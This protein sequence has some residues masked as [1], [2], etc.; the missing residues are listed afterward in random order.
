[1]KTLPEE[2]ISVGKGQNY[3]L[4]GDNAIWLKKIPDN[5]IDSIVTDPP[6]GISFMARGWDSDKGGRDHWIKWMQ[7][8]ATECKRVLKPGGHAFVWA[9]PR[10][11]HW[12]ATAWENAGFE[13]RDVV[14][15]IFGSGFPKSHNVEKAVQKIQPERSDEFKGIGT[16]LKPA[17]E[18]WILMRKP[19]AEKNVALNVL[20]YGTG[21]INIDESRV[22]AN[23]KEE[24]PESWFNSGKSKSG[25]PTYD[26]NLK[27][28]TESTV[29]ERL[30]DAGRFPANLILSADED[31]QVS[32]E[33]R[34]CFPDSKA[35]SYKGE[36]SKSGGIW[37]EST[38][39]PA[40]MEYGDS[41]NA[42]RFF[43]GIPQV[44]DL[45]DFSIYN[46]SILTKIKQL[47]GQHLT[48]KKT[49][50]TL[51]GVIQEVEKFI[52]DAEL[53]MSGNST[54][55]EKF[56]TDIVSITKTLIA[57]MIE[58]K[59][60]NVLPNWLIT[61]FTEENEQTIKLLKELNTE[62]VKSA[63]SIFLLQTFISEVLESIR[64]IA[65][66]V[67]EQDSN[68]GDYK[69]L[70]Y[71]AKASKSERNKGCEGLYILKDNT[72]KDDIEEIKHLLSI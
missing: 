67:A 31:G 19:L 34:D 40:G 9:I 27:S 14:A 17:R 16:A 62:D 71:Q 57:Q 56:L 66:I 63:K 1:M 3:L 44:V 35:G 53:L 70:L 43:K 68:N 6:A 37:S 7:E 58:L 72:P 13:I 24:R 54:T 22:E 51:D 47:C 26:G 2:N 29:G 65:E 39:K 59:T 64:A 45:H 52:Q 38:G 18:D 60:L 69:S 30:H 46:R 50:I 41:G 49:D 36:G 11:S 10:T 32:E 25:E 12:T 20:K 23:W 55:I 48:K 5:S 15:H 33:V 28:L 4:V 21:G 61:K 8:V 42:S